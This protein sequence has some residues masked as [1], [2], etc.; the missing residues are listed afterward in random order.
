MMNEDVVIRPFEATDTADLSKIWLEAS[1]IAHP[2]IGERRLTDQRGLI[3][4]QYLPRSE[5]WVATMAGRPVGF[6]SLL[7]TFIG[8]L[9]I[10][11]ERQG[12]GIGGKLISHALKLKGELT[13]EVYTENTQAVSFYRRIGFQELSRRSVDDEGFPFESARLHLAG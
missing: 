7:Q 1:L 8:G 12:S 9:F 5:T 13:L 4:D 10:T 11:P 3:E 6:I 2:F